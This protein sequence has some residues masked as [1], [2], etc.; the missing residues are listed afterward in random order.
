MKPISDKPTILMLG[1]AGAMGRAALEIIAGY[2]LVQQIIVADQDIKEA[3]KVVGAI[4]KE[5][6]SIR[7]SSAQIDVSN[8][9][10]LRKLI[11]QAD[12]VLNTTGPFYKYGAHI[13]HTCIE[14]GCHYFDICDDWEPTIEMLA[15]HDFAVQNDVLAVIG[16]GASPGVS[17]LLAAHA[18]KRLDSVKDIY[19]AWPIGDSLT[20]I[21]ETV[22]HGEESEQ[23]EIAVSAAI[24]HWMQQISGEIEIWET[25]EQITRKPLNA[26]ELDYPEFGKGHAYSVGHPE[27]VTLPV[28][29]DASGNSVNLMVMDP[30]TAAY[31]NSLRRDI[32]RGKLT[33][34]QA[35][36]LVYDIPKL[37]AVKAAL[38][39]K[40]MKGSGNLP[41]FFALVTGVKNDKPISVGVHLLTAPPTMAVITGAPLALGLKQFLEGQIDTVGV[42]PPETVINAEQ[43][44]T[45]LGPYSQPAASKLDEMIQRVETSG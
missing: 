31:I 8:S 42:H 1:G 7:I 10:A 35:A 40:K 43:L 13:L 21:T 28:S 12:V 20:A 9:E 26:V 3:E 34:E 38:Q 19:T 11:D 16:L 45:E 25:G 24:I 2:P 27:P 36:K 23:T 14:A 6:S 29:F 39:S 17:N 33:L 4:V 15:L 5:Q 37:R 30:S 44:L 18:A 32:D 22:R 41:P